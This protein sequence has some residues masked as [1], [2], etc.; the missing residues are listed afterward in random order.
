MS[1]LQRGAKWTTAPKPQMSEAMYDAT[2]PIDS[3]EVYIYMCVYHLT[4][5]PLYF[6]L[7][8]EVSLR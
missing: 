1:P 7:I 8:E 2:Y 6:I 3:V 4:I 5:N